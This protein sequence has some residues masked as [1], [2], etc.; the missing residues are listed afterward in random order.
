MRAAA[1]AV[2][3]TR[4]I[5][6]ALVQVGSSYTCELGEAE[7]DEPPDAL[8]ESGLLLDEGHREARGLTDLG[9]EQR[10]PDRRLV[11]HR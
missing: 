5:A 3:A 7:L 2:G 1:A 6:S 4:R 9:P 10:F 8:A 11:D